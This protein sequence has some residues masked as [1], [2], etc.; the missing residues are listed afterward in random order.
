L[1]LPLL[2]G[3]SIAVVTNPTG[4]MKDGTFLVDFLL[5]NNVTIKTIFAPEHGF[6]GD[7]DAGEQVKNGTDA[8]TGIPIISLYGKIRS[9]MQS[10]SKELIWC[11]L[12][13]RMW[14]FD[15]IPI[16]LLWHW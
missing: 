13:F 15:F 12:I 3:K 4:K 7:A 9:L 6:R 16:F 5:K 11:C 2:K 8:K 14:A 1:Y 10:N